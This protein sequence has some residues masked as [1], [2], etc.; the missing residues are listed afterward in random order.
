MRGGL[1]GFFEAIKRFGSPFDVSISDEKLKG[2]ANKPCFQSIHRN[3]TRSSF[4]QFFLTGLMGGFGL[5]I[6]EE[7]VLVMLPAIWIIHFVG[8]SFGMFGNL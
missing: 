2:W 5:A 1:T 4:S 3:Y 8:S 7:R 6:R